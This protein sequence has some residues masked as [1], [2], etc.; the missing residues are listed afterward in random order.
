MVP[1]WPCAVPNSRVAKPS[2]CVG[3]PELGFGF[4]VPK[5]LIGGTVETRR[6][7]SNDARVPSIRKVGVEQ[8]QAQSSLL[9]D[10]KHSTQLGWFGFASRGL[11]VH[12]LS[13]RP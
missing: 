10:S 5:I 6:A 9:R 4:R 7:D 8:T 1:L 12:T 3:C 2:Q 13:P 11:G